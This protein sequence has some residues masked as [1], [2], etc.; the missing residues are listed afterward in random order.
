MSTTAQQLPAIPTTIERRFYSR[1]IPQAPIYVAIDG[2]NEGLLINVSENGLLLSTPAELRCNFV[3][4]IS[5]PL[6]GL[7]KPVQV[8]VRVVWASEAGK[9]AGI[10]L[11]D[12]SEHDREQIRKWG[13]RESTPSL[14]REH[15]RHWVVAKT[16]TA[17]SAFAGKARSENS[18]SSRALRFP[19]RGSKAIYFR[20]CGQDEVAPAHGRG[21]S[22][23]CVLAKIWCARESFRAFHRKSRWERL[24]YGTGSERPTKSAKS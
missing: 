23:Q 16:S 19:G 17:P 11:L 2:N 6:N 21:L 8:N 4:R 18:T 13:A 14:Q 7:P 22:Y 15:N 12:L 1:I 5:I 24:S 10:Q 20:R 9:L 3:A